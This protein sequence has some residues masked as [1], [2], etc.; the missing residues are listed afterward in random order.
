MKHFRY[1]NPAQADLI[2]IGQY[3]L[4]AWGEAQTGIYLDQIEDCCQRLAQ[5]PGMG[6]LWMAAY[7]GLRRMEQGASRYFLSATG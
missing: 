7:P 2:D 3:T 4:R 6:R 5:N 1:S